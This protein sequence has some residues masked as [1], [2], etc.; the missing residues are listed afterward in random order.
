MEAFSELSPCSDLDTDLL[1]VMREVAKMQMGHGL[2]Y[3]SKILEKAREEAQKRFEEAQRR[4]AE[5]SEE[6]ERAEA[7]LLM[8]AM[9]QLLASER[10]LEQILEDIEFNEELRRLEAEIE[11]LGKESQKLTRADL[12]EALSEYERKGLIDARTPTIKLTSKGSRVLGRGFLTR[13]LE[14]LRRRGVGPH[15]VEELGH[16]PWLSSTYRPYEY[17]D[18]YERINIERSLLAALE[19]SRGLSDL[20]LSDFK[21][22]DSMHHTEVYFGILVDQSGSMNRDGKLEAAVETALALSEL[23]RIRFP[24]DKLRVFTFSEEVKEVEPWELPSIAVPM[25][26]TDIRAAMREFRLAAAHEAGNKQAHLITDSA[27][28]FE[29]GEFVG[30]ERALV[31]VLMEARR[32]RMEDIVLNIVMLDDDPEL[33]EMAKAMA[34]QNLGRVFFT[35]PS[36]LGETLVEDYLLSKR[37]LIRL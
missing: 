29:D 14:S 20:E 3:D 27:P 9:E 22:Y 24:E 19:R 23:M 12:G 33:R 15:R 21:V 6:L 17:G 31:G 2:D 25:K 37:E 16:G 32:Y 30:F 5:A 34:K 26:Y 11:A 10:S 8:E 13:I 35:R 18:S 7:E 4:R 36:D 28:N 1:K